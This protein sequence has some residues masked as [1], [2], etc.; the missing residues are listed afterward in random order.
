[1]TP[2]VHEVPEQQQVDCP[3]SPIPVRMNEFQC[4]WAPKKVYVKPVCRSLLNDL[5]SEIIG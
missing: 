5:K 2:N 3:S 4:P 1:M